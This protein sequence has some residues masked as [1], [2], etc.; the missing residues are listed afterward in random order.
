M[1]FV[2]DTDT[3]IYF[4]K[5]QVEVAT[6]M[7][8]TDPKNLFITIINQ[9]ELLFGAY[10]SSQKEKNLQKIEGFINNFVVLPFCHPSS[11][12]FADLKHYL[13]KKGIMLADMDLMIA[14]ICLQNK[15][16]LVTNNNRHFDRVLGLK[17]ENWTTA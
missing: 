10:K 1:N 6:H 8:N 15:M 12:H 11:Y 14:S 17:I 9:A 13:Q 5:G 3:L 16:T 4:L 2:L 7:A